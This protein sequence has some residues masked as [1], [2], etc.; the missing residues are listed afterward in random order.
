MIIAPF[1]YVLII[2]L[3][4]GNRTDEAYCP[5]GPRTTTPFGGLRDDDG[6]WAPAINSREWWVQVGGTDNV[7]KHADLDPNWGQDGSNEELTRHIL[8]C[9]Y[10]N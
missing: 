4:F 9:K 8:C 7:C 6:S 5:M 1:V 2:I 3:F 10:V